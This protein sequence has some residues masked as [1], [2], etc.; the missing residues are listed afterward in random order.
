MSS[1]INVEKKHKAALKELE[2]GGIFFIEDVCVIMAISKMT[3]YKYWR[4]D[5]DIYNEIVEALDRNRVK[6]KMGI[7]QKLYKSGKASELIALYKLI[8]TNEERKKL[9]QGYMDVTTKGKPMGEQKLDL[10]KLD[11]ET[12]E[13]LLEAANQQD[14]T[15]K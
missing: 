10:S 8:G 7:R 2:K 1:A 5:S 9:S 6:A 15:K 11:D 13:K 3:F 14:S 4:P 12:L